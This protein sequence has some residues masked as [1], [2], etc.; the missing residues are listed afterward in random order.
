MNQ[1]RN[2]NHNVDIKSTQVA[3]AFKSFAK[4]ALGAGIVTIGGLAV[5]I[6]IIVNDENNKEKEALSRTKPLDTSSAILDYKRNPVRYNENWDG[7]YVTF[8]GRVKDLS[9]YEFAFVPVATARQS[10]TTVKCD[11]KYSE[12][13]KVAQLDSGKYV[14]VLGK[15]SLRQVDSWKFEAKLSDCTLSKITSGSSSIG[16][17]HQQQNNATPIKVS[18]A[19]NNANTCWFQMA[20]GATKGAKCDISTRVNSNGHNVIDLI[21]PNGIKRSIVLWTNGDAEVFLHGKRYTGIYSTSINRTSVTV[22]GGT[23][24]FSSI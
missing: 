5:I 4:F 9:S 20:S 24:Q 8:S 1:T 19:S 22:G 2:Y 3:G 7:K 12:K 21:E 6:G 10:S 13:S 16:K 11:F 18:A 23:F 14:S 15:L 17:I